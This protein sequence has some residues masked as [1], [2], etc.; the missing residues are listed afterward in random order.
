MSLSAAHAATKTSARISKVGNVRILHLYGTPYEMGRQHGRLLR[1]EVQELYKNYFV[2]FAGGDVQVEIAAK[3]AEF[4]MLPHIPKKYVEEMRGLADGSGLSFKKVLTAQAFLDIKKIVQCST[5]ALS[6]QASSESEPMLGRNLDFPSLG[7][8][9]RHSII[10]VRH[11]AQGQST[12]SVGWPLLLGTFSGM[13]SSGVSLAMMEVYTPETSIAGMPYAFQY[14]RALEASKSTREVVSFIQKAKHTAS[15]NL[16]VLDSQGD[17]SLLEITAKQV[18]V[19]K[20]SKG[21]LFA[22]NHHRSSAL[23][24]KTSCWRYPIIEKRLRGTDVKLSPKQLTE[25]LDQVS[26]GEQNLQSMVFFPRSRK[27]HLAVGQLPASKGPFI[28]IPKT[29]LFDQK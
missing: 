25:L 8:A 28:E 18:A 2:K 9:H 24:Q 14:R 19:R 11:P 3:L 26:M 23:A 17:A 27:L 13:N 21:K 16:M 29:A 5:I 22:T 7:I 10:V 20:A 15:N 4:S 6:A 1:T 12:V